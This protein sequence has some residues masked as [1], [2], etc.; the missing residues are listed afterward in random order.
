MNNFTTKFLEEFL[1]SKN[2]SD[3]DL[4]DCLTELIR[5]EVENGVNC[6]LQNELKSFLGFERNAQGKAKE[7]GDSRNGFYERKI[8]TKF[9]EIVA[10]I[11]RDRNGE[12]ETK[13]FEP[14]KRNTRDISDLILKLY[15]SNLSDSEMQTIIESLLNKKYS[16]STISSITDAVKEDVTKFNN[17]KLKEKYFA[18]FLDAT[19]IP[20]RRNTVDKEGVNI[21]MGIDMDG[22]PE[23][24]GFNISPNETKNGWEELIVNLKERGVKTAEILV[25]DGFIG[26]EDLI[27][28]YLPGCLHQRCFVHLVRNLCDKVRKEDQKIVASEFMNLA[29]QNSLQDALKE[30]ELFVERWGKK[31]QNISRWAQSI[32]I[33][34]IFNFYHMPKELWSVVYTNNRIEGFNKEIKRNAKTHVVWPT[35]EAEEKFLVTLFNKYNMK[36]GKRRIHGYEYIK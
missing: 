34:S 1:E 33:E 8:M 24:L 5:K 29:K 13:M 26:I 21:L 15:K 4:G 7:K 16:T 3:F 27:S 10:E 31:Y 25:S 32:P 2:S 17:R 12:Y 22:Y 9:G 11:P 19:Y 20:L 28:K 36:I 6:V 14:Y 35:Q 30:F 18:L 23:V